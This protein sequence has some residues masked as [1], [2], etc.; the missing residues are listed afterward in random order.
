MT[1]F[2]SGT[3][4]VVGLGYVGA[5]LALALSAHYPVI[6]Y[7]TDPAR[8]DELRRA[9]D[10]TRELDAA[11][12]ARARWRLTGDSR[13]LRD[14]DIVI[15]T[16]P[17]PVTAA[18]VPDMGCL[19]AASRAVGA[20]MK[21]GAIVVY[22][23]T[24]YPGATED[25]CLPEL[26]RASALRYPEDF[27]IGYSPERVN[28][29]DKVHRLDNTTKI[30]AADRPEVLELL[31][32]VYGRLTTVHRAGSIAVAEAAKALENIQRDVNIGLVNEVY[33]ILSRI[34]VDM[35][36]VLAAA[37]TKWNFLPFTPGLV[38]GHCIGVDPYYMTHKAASEGASARIISAAREANDAMAAFLV[39]KLVKKLV[40]TGGLRRDAVIT[41]L[42]A[43]FKEDVPDVRNSKVADL[44]AELARYGLAAQVVDPLADAREA[45]DELGLR[46]VTLEDAARNPADA[47]IL[48]VPHAPFLAGGGWGQVVP[49]AR[50]QGA[51][52]L[53]LKARLSRPAPAHITLMH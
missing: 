36:E 28:P 49:L 47:V 50:L 44:C 11:R 13:G 32:R 51:V 15:V 31:A 45:Q 27:A 38:G 23:S 1:M 20:A 52:V 26:R 3:I 37:G 5:P 41:V 7:D 8:V 29:G 46:L 42:G 53:D 10:R 35:H 6:A 2:K 34:G 22:E 33:Q 24:V 17:T 4:A 25:V 40:S 21:R 18:N 43:T 14:A 12:L 16:V 39:D 9:E 19:V 30:V 48:A